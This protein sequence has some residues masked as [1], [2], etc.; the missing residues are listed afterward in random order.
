[1]YKIDWDTENNLLI[2]KNENAFLNNEYRPV[3]PEELKNYGFDKYCSFD[4]SGTA[5]VLW[6]FRYRY[7][8]RGWLIAELADN[9]CLTL[10]SVRILDD[11]IVGCHL[12]PIDMD[13][14]FRKNRLLMDQLVQDTLLR[15]YCAYT[16][17]KDRVDY[18]NVAYSG[19]KDSM[20]LLDLVK[21]I[22]PHDRFFVTWG[23]T[24]MEL[25]MSVETV[26]KERAR[27]EAEGIRFFVI[28]SPHD[29]V[30]DWERIGPP[31]FDNRWC[32]SV[33]KSV[34]QI[35]Q[36]MEYVGRADAKNLLFV[37]N[38]AD[39]GY[40]RKN[41]TLVEI[42]IKQKDQVHINGIINWNS[43][44]VFL[45]LMMNGIEFNPAYREGWMRIG[46]KLCPLASTIS[47]GSSYGLRREELE[48]YFNV[49]RS[50]YRG[51]FDSEDALERYVNGGEW[52]FRKGSDH[53]KYSVDYREV[54]RDGSLHLEI[55]HPATNWKEWFR[56]LGLLRS[57]EGTQDGPETT[58]Y[59]L[60]RGGKEYAF[61]VREDGGR[62]DISL[63]GTWEESFT[64]LVKKVFRKAAACVACRACEVGCPHG[65]L[66]FEN[67]QPVIDDSCL[68]CA[69]C[70][71]H[72]RSCFAFDSW[73]SVDRVL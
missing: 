4:E 34:P 17:W 44:E 37:G 72:I 33:R 18:I 73:Y 7:F 9:G 54:L 12:E 68:H 23:D 71:N 8:Y 3:F 65:H 11:S 50:A 70:H 2:L 29:P 69:E 48:P 35:L 26:E 32:C 27:C 30:Q 60:E 56:T 16:E 1:M 59:V 66:H 31:S 52:R 19:G 67:G 45:Y 43:L 38:R 49:I 57:A 64:G 40:R 21:R 46:C 28:R 6:A 47:L 25:Q 63:P 24:G 42:G 14:W 22:I 5:P 15:I 36:M 13:L 51:S 53:T 58:R 39:E 20:V 41:N 61:T 55:G 10:P 62:M